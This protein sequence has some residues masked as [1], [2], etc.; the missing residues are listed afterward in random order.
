MCTSVGS[1]MADTQ[2]TRRSNKPLMERRRRERINHCLNELK[3]LVLTAQR[4]DPTRYNKLEK[5]D[6]LEMTVRHV[7]A[8]HRQETSTSSRHLNADS[9]AKYRAGF[10]Q[11][12][13]EVSRF[14]A[15]LNGLPSDLHARVLSHLSSSASAEPSAVKTE[16]EVA[17][18]ATAKMSPQ[19]QQQ[20]QAPQGSLAG[21]PLLQ[22]RLASGQLALVL[23]S[24][25]AVPSGNSSP[26]NVAFPEAAGAPSSPESARGSPQS[27]PDSPEG[28]VSPEACGNTDRL[29][30]SRLE[31]SCSQTR[32]SVAATG[33]HPAPQV[34]PLDLATPHR[35][36][37]PAAPA[38]TRHRAITVSVGVAHSPPPLPCPAIPHVTPRPSK[39]VAVAPGASGQ[40]QGLRESRH[41]PYHHHHRHHQQNPHWRPW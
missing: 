11:C 6:I 9:S 32:L 39:C 1:N 10:T 15:S 2:K 27:T 38:L 40:F 17:C 8:L 24:W 16:A 30:S 22:T 13:A 28:R 20:Q 33:H 26:N 7:E 34:A 5:A 14:L 23:P 3:N 37:G 21:V 25:T 19:Q 31:T 35:R 4:K 41:A 36:T 29:P 12:A 18:V